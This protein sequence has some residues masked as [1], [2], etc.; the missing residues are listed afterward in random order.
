MFAKPEDGDV[1]LTAW[2]FSM[3]NLGYA[4]YLIGNL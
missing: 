4:E 2:F 1:N 3:G